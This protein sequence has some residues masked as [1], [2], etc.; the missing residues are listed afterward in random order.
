MR[1]TPFHSTCSTVKM[2][3]CLYICC[4]FEISNEHRGPPSRPRATSRTM[5]DGRRTSRR[6]SFNRERPRERSRAERQRRQSHHRSES[7]SVSV[8]PTPSQY[9]V[10][11]SVISENPQLPTTH[12]PT[13]RLPSTSNPRPHNPEP[14][15]PRP[16]QRAPP[17]S[18]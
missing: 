13:L 11:N 5:Q 12:V 7:A 6:H 16:K 2:P 8:S 17:P 14:C 4:H 1:N 15:F 18:Q 9:L 3:P 10:A